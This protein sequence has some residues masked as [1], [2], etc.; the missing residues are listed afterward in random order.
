LSRTIVSARACASGVSSGPPSVPFTAGAFATAGGG[1]ACVVASPAVRE[2]SRG[3]RGDRLLISF[4]SPSEMRRSETALARDQPAPAEDSE[5]EHFKSSGRVLRLG[6]FELLWC[7]A[8]HVAAFVPMS[9]RSCAARVTPR[10][11]LP[12]SIAPCT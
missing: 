6:R 9:R 11:S 1:A 5:S 10:P 7:V 3:R 2:A 12:H 8:P 4:A